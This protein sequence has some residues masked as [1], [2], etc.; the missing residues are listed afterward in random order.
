MMQEVWTW[1][2]VQEIYAVSGG[3]ALNFPIGFAIGAVH[4]RK[5]YRGKIKVTFR[6]PN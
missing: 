2:G 5:N 3:G 1:G 6:P 4:F